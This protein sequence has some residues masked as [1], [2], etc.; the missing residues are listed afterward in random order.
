MR[1]LRDAAEGFIL[2]PATQEGNTMHALSIQAL[3][4]F[5]AVEAILAIVGLLATWG[6]SKIAPTEIAKW[7]NLAIWIVI[8]VAMLIRLLNFVGIS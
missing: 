6:V 3:I 8:G 7:I 4:I 5:L 1:E 2:G